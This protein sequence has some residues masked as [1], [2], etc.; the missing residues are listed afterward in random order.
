MVFANL[1]QSAGYTCTLK[2]GN[3]RH[4]LIMPA[5]VCGWKDGVDT[6][7]AV[8]SGTSLVVVAAIV[9]REI[10]TPQNMVYEVHTM[11]CGCMNLPHHN[12]CHYKFNT[13]DQSLQ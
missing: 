12:C 7:K 5:M 11:F 10:H 4:I 1:W 3:N 6:G 8:P 13:C 9:V 2:K